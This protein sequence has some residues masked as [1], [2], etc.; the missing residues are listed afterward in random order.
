[1]QT[2]VIEKRTTGRRRG[3]VT[4]RR[5]LLNQQ[6]EVIQEG[7]TETLVMLQAPGELPR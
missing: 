2:E 1:V 6:D 5:Q 4:W 3:L 7:I